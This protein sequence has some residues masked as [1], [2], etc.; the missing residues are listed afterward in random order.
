MN[1]R[2][3][4][5]TLLGIVSVTAIIMIIIVYFFG[6]NNVKV[7]EK[8]VEKEVIVYRDAPAAPA[9]NIPAGA[10]T[11]TH[12]QESPVQAEIPAQVVSA[13]AA[14]TVDD[15]IREVESIIP[16]HFSDDQCRVYYSDG[17][18]VIEINDNQNAKFAADLALMAGGNTDA[19]NEWH[20]ARSAMLYLSHEAK[21]A[22]NR[23]GLNDTHISVMLVNPLNTENMLLITLDNTIQY[24]FWEELNGD[25]EET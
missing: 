4:L 5:Q 19:I 2:Y 3:L 12:K 25:T 15:F 24:D 11:F 16:N 7:V 13:P 1:T 6:D 8:V 10:E 22:A 23:V 20:E 18:I 9:S 21:A 14:F 17:I